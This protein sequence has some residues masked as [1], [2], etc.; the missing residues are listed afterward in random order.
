[1]EQHIPRILTVDDNPDARIAVQG[2][3]QREHMHVMQAENAEDG[4]NAISRAH[5][6]L[7]ITDLR[8]KQKS[9]LDLVLETREHGVRVPFILL[10]AE[11]D[12]AIR[13]VAAEMGVVAVLDKPVRK[14]I[15]LDHVSHALSNSKLRDI[16]SNDLHQRC[17]A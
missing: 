13:K 3:L 5:F 9:G 12:L 1:M 14:R 4:L 10:T 16:A 8:M 6:D 17:T 7:V 15:L 11:A 2:V